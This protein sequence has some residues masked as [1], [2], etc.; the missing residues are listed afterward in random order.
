MKKI[1]AVLTLMLIFAGCATKGKEH[2]TTGVIQEVRNGGVAVVISHEEFPGFMEGMTMAF[3]TEK[4]SLAQG[5]AAGDKIQFTI[6]DRS[7]SWRISA[8]SKIK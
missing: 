4:P 5:L 8:I 7:G 1:F 2:S 6:S 3:D